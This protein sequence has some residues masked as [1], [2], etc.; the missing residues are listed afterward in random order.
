[1]P[2]SGWAIITCGSFWNIAATAI[3]G[4]FCATA[5][6]DCSVLVLMKKS[7]RP[8]ASRSWLFT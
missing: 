5:S 4:M 7:I 6:N 2:R 8:T 1:M 3:V